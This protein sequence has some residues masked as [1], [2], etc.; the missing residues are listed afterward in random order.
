MCALG[1]REGSS[2]PLVNLEDGQEELDSEQAHG[3][4]SSQ[5]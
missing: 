5:V 3:E 2:I 4:F 1:A